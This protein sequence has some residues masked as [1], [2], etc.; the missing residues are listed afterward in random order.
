MNSTQ[1]PYAVPPLSA[2][3]QALV[4]KIN[5]DPTWDKTK[6][7]DEL[8]THLQIAVEVELAT[9]PIYLGTYYSIDRRPSKPKAFPTSA[10]S[11]FADQAGALI[12]S[13]AVE[14][15]LHMSLSGNVLY[16][17]GQ[18][19]E[20]Y[21]KAPNSYPA[22]LP[23][24]RVNTPGDSHD[25]SRNVPIPLARFSFDQLSHFLAIEYPAKSDA[26]PE[27]DDWDT[28]GQIYSYVRCIIES[29]W[30]DDG[31][32]QVQKDNGQQIAS[33]EYSP[34]NIDTVYPYKSFDFDNAQVVGSTGSAS[35]AAAYAS[36]EDSHVGA[37]QLLQITCC[38]DALEA[39]ATIEFQG[40]G[41]DHER[42]DDPSKDELSHYYK[43]LTLQS[44][45]DGYD[46]AY[47]DEAGSAD[48]NVAAAPMPPAIPE[49]QFSQSDLDQ[50][51]SKFPENP[52]LDDFGTG[53]D[54][55]G[56]QALVN[57]ADGLFQYMLI[58]SET[59]YKIPSDK[60]KVYF[61]RT[62]H[63]SMIWVLDKLLQSMRGV[64][65]V[66]GKYNLCSRF[67][68]ID[69]GD[70]SDAF[71]K[72]CQMIDDFRATYG[73][74][75][76]TPADWYT[77]TDIDGY[78]GAI[79]D[80]PDVGVF[81]LTSPATD[82]T[83][84]QTPYI[85]EGPYAGT[86]KWPTSPPKDD[87]LPPGAMRHSCMGLNSCKDQGRTGSNA[88]AGQGY[89]STALKYNPADP[90][91]PLY[92]DHLCHVLNDCRHQGGCGL[93]GTQE[94]L[95]EPGRNACQTLGSCATPINAERFITDGDL[96]GE[97]VWVQ[98]RKV[99]TEKVWPQLREANP[100][101]PPNPPQVPGSNSN[102]DLFRYGPTIHWIES[103]GGGM[104]ACGAS[105][106]SG[107]GSCA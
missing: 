21:K 89:C 60:Q 50:F 100:D 15:M 75:G 10:A 70:R 91:S 12:M 49:Q 31:D 55:Q 3:E 90:S 61:N 87:E 67:S 68:N 25:D 64:S 62:M 41:F 58:M 69:L 39:I 1:T 9:I 104:T 84:L 78:L 45:L 20:L 107:A 106:M 83:F 65:T 63:Q 2:S 32:F 95:S 82:P 42:Y 6:A 48:S 28:I 16:A 4:D 43:F 92:S 56:R 36:K 26:P 54:D 102:P 71:G 93:Y 34:N 47:L 103:E 51:V 81:W 7:L 105:G 86:P 38:Q 27:A 11:R 94:E 59:I 40:E 101:L 77:V 52:T 97:S 23:H 8:K 30:I 22:I 72:L 18:M 53:C 98:A 5:N 14:E 99:F 44:E 73:A 29:K 19:P 80:L 46:Q 33:G 88:C 57:I 24:H 74:T 37:S 79:K 35:E 66:D 13:V 17:L 96:R 76:T 85:T